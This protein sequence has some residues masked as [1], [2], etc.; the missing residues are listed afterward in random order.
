MYLGRIAPRE[1]GRVSLR[2]CE[3]SEAIHFR[4]AK[5]E[6]HSLSSGARSRDPLARAMTQGR[7]H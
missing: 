2:R 4:R 1:C 7:F 6:S 5:E 3:R